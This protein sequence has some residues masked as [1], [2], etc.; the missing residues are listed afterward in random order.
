MLACAAIGMAVGAFA[1]FVAIYDWGQTIRRQGGCDVYVTIETPHRVKSTTF[2]VDDVRAKGYIADC[3]DRIARHGAAHLRE[4][5]LMRVVD[6][7]RC[8]DRC[9]LVTV[10]TCGS[11]SGFR[12]TQ[13]SY[14]QVD[15][16]TVVVIELENGE[17]WVTVLDLP[18]VQQSTQ[19][20]I[21]LPGDA[22]RVRPVPDIHKR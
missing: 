5:D 17:Q 3:R 10:R 15:R 14:F 1:A 12:L 11:E 9:F 8:D 4:C 7:D 18:D 20:T 13:N 16:Y 22:R 6:G 2:G 19:A 21:R